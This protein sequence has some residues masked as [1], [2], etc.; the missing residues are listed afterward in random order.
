MSKVYKAFTLDSFDGSGVRHFVQC[1]E[2]CEINGVRYVQLQKTLHEIDATW[3]DTRAG[4]IRDVAARAR[5]MAR[6]LTVQADNLLRQAMAA[7]V[8][9]G[10][11]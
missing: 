3:H 6:T 10:A 11:A 5:E 4:A 9:G 8:E 1:G 2:V 7:S